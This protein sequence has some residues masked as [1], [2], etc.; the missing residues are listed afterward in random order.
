MNK[1][2][3]EQPSPWRKSS[4][5]E[6]CYGDRVYLT[7]SGRGQDKR[8]I[9]YNDIYYV[10]CISL[11][12]CIYVYIYIYIYICHH[13]SAAISHNQISLQNA[14]TRG[15]MHGICGNMR[16]LHN[17]YIYI[18]IYIYVYIIS[19]SLSIYIYIYIYTYRRHAALTRHADG[20][21]GGARAR[22]RHKATC[23]VSVTLLGTKTII[24]SPSGSHWQYGG[25]F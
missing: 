22:G 2:I 5:R 21:A 4:K 23:K 15:Q 20:G 6:S 7:A 1:H 24:L 14:V 18:Y 12:V 17:I 19:L 25:R 9:A 8:G 3:S 16:T 13:T 11:Y 10:Q